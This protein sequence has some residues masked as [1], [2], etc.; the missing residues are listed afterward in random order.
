MSVAERQELVDVR[1]AAALVDRHTETIRRWI[2]SGKLPAARRGNRLLVKRDDLRLASGETAPRLTLAE[3][4]KMARAVKRSRAEPT[5]S[6]AADLID[7][8]RDERTRRLLELAG[9]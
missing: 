7:E 5:G 2:W 8:G 4:A 6:T 9:R 3:W 1:Q